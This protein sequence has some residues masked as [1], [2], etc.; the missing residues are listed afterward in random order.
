M[1]TNLKGVVF[2]QELELG[3]SSNVHRNPEFS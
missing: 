3:L 2:I 1:R